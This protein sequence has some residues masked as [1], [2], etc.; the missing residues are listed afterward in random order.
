MHVHHCIEQGGILKV[1]WG[2]SRSANRHTETEVPTAQQLAIAK[3]SWP[4]K[5]YLKIAITIEE[6]PLKI[7]PYIPRPYKIRR[8]LVLDKLR[9]Q[10]TWVKVLEVLLH[11]FVCEDQEKGYEIGT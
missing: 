2:P 4:L 9:A 8:P 6:N 3:M 1:R 10:Q 11:H 5:F 7:M